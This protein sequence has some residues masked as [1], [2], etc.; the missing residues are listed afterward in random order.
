[1]LA[2]KLSGEQH[3]HYLSAAIDPIA[4]FLI[5]GA[6]LLMA[7]LIYAIFSPDDD[8]TENDRHDPPSTER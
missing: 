3:A 2:L 4:L 1:M 6:G 8:R 7:G 5:V